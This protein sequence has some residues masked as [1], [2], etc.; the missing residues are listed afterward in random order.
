M[1]KLLIWLTALA[2]LFFVLVIA[3]ILIIPKFIK[4]ESYIPQLEQQV[5]DVTGRPFQLGDDFSISIF[6]WTSIAFND[7]QLGNPEN[8]DSEDFIRID[9]F[10]ARVKLLPLISGQVE[11]EKF[12]LDGF[13]LSLVKRTDGKDNWSSPAQADA[14][15]STTKDQQEPEPSS[16]PAVSQDD[17]FIISSLE[18]QEFALTN[19]TIIYLDQITNQKTAVTDINLILQDVSLQKPVQIDFKAIVDNDPIELSG[20]IGPLGR[21]PGQEAIDVNL[22]VKT[23]EAIAVKLEGTIS[24]AT[25]TP[26]FS[27]DIAIDPFSPRALLDKLKFGLPITPS[28]PQTLLNASATLKIVGSPSAFSIEDSTIKLD[29]STLNLSAIV[30]EFSKPDISFNIQLDSINLDR[31]LPTPAKEE[32]TD[33]PGD[34]GS[35]TTT[36]QAAEGEQS[37]GVAATN[38]GTEINQS[39]ESGPDYT[40]LRK[41]KL[42]GEISTGQIIAHGA[43]F[44]SISMKIQGTDG[45]FTIEPLNVRLYEGDVGLLANIDFSNANLVGSGDL[46]VTN[47]QVGP[48]LEDAL[49]N[50]QIEGGLAA[51]I[52]LGFTGDNADEIRQ[53][54]N[55]KG[56]LKFVDGALIGLD[57]ADM[58]RSLASGLGY[59][60]PEEKPKTDF[61]ELNIPFTITNGVFNTQNSS[62]LSPLLRVKALGSANLVSEALDLKVQP[63]IV[64]TLKGQG[65]SKARSG[66]TVPIIVEGTFSKPTFSADLKELVTGENLQQALENPEAAKETIETLE[67]SGKGL[68]KSFGF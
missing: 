1:K 20:S 19:G 28:D 55:G 30:Q 36:P 52:A 44:D 3:A 58:A 24:D 22:V 6:P 31:Y 48:L 67:E 16:T 41:L 40:A 51:K 59:E 12:I 63:K 27:F 4:V 49:K 47:L 23:L 13:A 50:K 45:I 34:S 17:E 60:K 8:F 32:E 14:P 29:E 7:L 54:L 56:E 9:S 39:D 18:V 53:S 37:Q 11:V 21:V 65:D 42:M 15:Q 62:L 57:I 10:E 46:T 61:A 35:A 5:S 43:K 66:V 33:T 26:Q 64:G 2:G 68:L 25:T 38:R